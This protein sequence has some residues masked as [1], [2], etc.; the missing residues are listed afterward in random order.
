MMNMMGGLGGMGGMGDLGGGTPPV[1]DPETAYATQIQQLV[2]LRHLST[3]LTSCSHQ[4]AEQIRM[5]CVK[6]GTL[7]HSCVPCHLSKA[8]GRNSSC[9]ITSARNSV[10]DLCASAGGHGVL[11]P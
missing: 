11:R 7:T 3:R 2:R 9:S 8:G 4:H 6:Q 5:N 1:A 10:N